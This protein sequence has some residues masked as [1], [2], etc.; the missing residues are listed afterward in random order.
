MRVSTGSRVFVVSVRIVVRTSVRVVRACRPWVVRATRVVVALAT[1]EV[2]ETPTALA[3]YTRYAVVGG[4]TASALALA[5]SFAGP[6]TSEV[7]AVVGVVSVGALAVWIAVRLL[8]EA[9]LATGWDLSHQARLLIVATTRRIARSHGAH[10]MSRTLELVCEPRRILV[11][12]RDPAVL[13]R[14]LQGS[15]KKLVVKHAVNAVPGLSV[16]CEAVDVLNTGLAHA[17]FLHE[18]EMSARELCAARAA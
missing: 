12:A 5:R 9:E 15:L 1:E 6:G 2:G 11:I 14:L 8:R 18:F 4:V 7:L 17:R 16:A 3:R 13:G 10:Q